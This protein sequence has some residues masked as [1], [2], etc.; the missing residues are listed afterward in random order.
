M[1]DRRLEIL[2]EWWQKR[3]ELQ[4]KIIWIGCNP[5]EPEIYKKQV[6]ETLALLRDFNKYSCEVARRLENVK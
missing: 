6:E 4:E 5:S 2:N 3:A 1:T